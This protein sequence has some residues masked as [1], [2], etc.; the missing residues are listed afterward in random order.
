MGLNIIILCKVELW[1]L[2][3]DCFDRRYRY[4]SSLSLLT[5]LEVINICCRL[6]S[7]TGS[8]L[9]DNDDHQRNVADIERST[10]WRT[11]RTRTPTATE[12]IPK[13]P[14]LFQPEGLQYHHPRV[15][16]KKER[17]VDAEVGK[18]HYMHVTRRRHYVV[19][20]IPG[21]QYYASPLSLPLTHP[22]P[23]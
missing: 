1:A 18:V 17:E 2:H 15:Q 22:Q 10:T 13:K 11:Q 4:F 3:N 14:L 20:A 6:W 9:N 23:C 12:Y 16:R 7:K 19:G 5:Y 8:E 21:R